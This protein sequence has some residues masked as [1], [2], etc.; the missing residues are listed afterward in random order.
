MKTSWLRILIW[1]VAWG[2]TGAL[3]GEGVPLARDLQLDGAEAR[4][5]GAAVLV[6]FVA[7]R[8]PYCDLALNEILIPTS[9]NPD[10]QRK[11]VMRRVQ[12]RSGQFLR[13]FDG[14]RVTHGEF[15]KRHGVVLVPTL[16]LF[17]PEGRLL[18]KPMVGITTVD[19]YSYELDLAIEAALGRLAPTPHPVPGSTTA[20]GGS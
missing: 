4:G 2:M 16:M 1:I 8:C 19:H 11:L 10:Y 14:R 13:D 7:A 3:A 18:T 9:R 6:V 17:D 20:G 12:V 15:A 5:R